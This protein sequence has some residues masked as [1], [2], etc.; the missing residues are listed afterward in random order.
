MIANNQCTEIFGYTPTLILPT[1]AAG[2]TSLE[3]DGC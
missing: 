2:S 3:A 1:A